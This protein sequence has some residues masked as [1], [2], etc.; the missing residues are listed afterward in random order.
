[1]PMNRNYGKKYIQSKYVLVLKYVAQEKEKKRKRYVFCKCIIILKITLTIY[2]ALS[3]RC[4]LINTISFS[5]VLTRLREA[6]E[7]SYFRTILE[8]LT[9][10]PCRY[11]RV[12]LQITRL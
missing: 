11:S 1:M 9:W 5:N 10:N 12:K 3:R 6:I 7:I 4:I 2:L 8:K